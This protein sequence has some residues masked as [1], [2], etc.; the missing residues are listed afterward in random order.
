MGNASTVTAASM[1]MNQAAP[2]WPGIQRLCLVLKMTRKHASSTEGS[3]DKG[4]AAVQAL[5]Y[6][7]FYS[8][9]MYFLYFTPGILPSVHIRHQH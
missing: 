9:P 4:P 7:G 1:N 3:T 6:W 5:F 2:G 8:I